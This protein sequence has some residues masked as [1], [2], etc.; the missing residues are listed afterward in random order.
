MHEETHQQVLRAAHAKAA[1]YYVQYA[2]TN[3]PPRDKRRNADDVKP[4]IEAVWQYCQAGQWQEAY[5][6][7]LE[8]GL[9]SDLS[10]WGRNAAL[11]ELCQLLLPAREWQ[12]ERSQ[13]ARIYAELGSVYDDLGKQQEALT[14][15]EQALDIRREVGDRGGEGTTLH[16]IGTLYFEQGHYDVALACFLLARGILE[17]VLSPHRDDEQSWIDDLRRRVGEKQFATLLARV[18]VQAQQ[19]VEQE[20]KNGL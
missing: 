11:L 17:E 8:E 3:C 19:V 9:F 15:Y 14:Y 6:L 7:M 13:A 4:L 1:R 5:D 2:E 12:P 16:N 10:R 18:E 20:L